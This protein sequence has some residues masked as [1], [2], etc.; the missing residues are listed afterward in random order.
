MVYREIHY[1]YATSYMAQQLG[2]YDVGCWYY[3]FWSPDPLEASYWSGAFDTA[4]SAS[5]A[6]KR[7]NPSSCLL[8]KK[9][10]IDQI[11]RVK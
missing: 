1:A 7:H 8:G 5:L 2:R 10:L 6:A 3:D 11:K 4:L 9:W